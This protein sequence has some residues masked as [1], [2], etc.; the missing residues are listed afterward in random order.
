MKVR[1]KFS[2]DG[3][4]EVCGTSGYHALFPESDPPCRA[5]GSVFRWIQPAYDHVFC[6]STWSWDGAVVGDY[7][8]LEIGR[9]YA[10]AEIA[11]RLDEQMAEGMHIVKRPQGR[12]WKSG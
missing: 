1:I 7:F 6:G 12:G 10:T 4:Y 8:D 2:K 3:S 5:P 11:A 9:R